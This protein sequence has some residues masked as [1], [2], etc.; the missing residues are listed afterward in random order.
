MPRRNQQTYTPSDGTLSLPP[1]MATHTRPFFL[2]LDVSPCLPTDSLVQLACMLPCLLLRRTLPCL[3][4][5]RCETTPATRAPLPPSLPPSFPARSL[6]PG[7]GQLARL[8]CLHACATQP[9][10]RV[11]RSSFASAPLRPSEHDS[12][13]LLPHRP[14]D[15]PVSVSVRRS[16]LRSRLQDQAAPSGC[17]LMRRPPP[18][19]PSPG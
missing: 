6:V 7:P 19:P 3:L 4:A 9:T 14:C 17:S 10:I 13:Y 18:P 15:R 1:S 12:R 2:S 8:P 5:V 11:L 16:S